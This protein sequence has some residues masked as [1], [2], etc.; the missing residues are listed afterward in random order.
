MSNGI[1]AQRCPLCTGQPAPFAAVRERRYLRCGRCLLTFLDPAQRPGRDEERAEYE[2]HENDPGD[3]GYRRFLSRLTDALVERLSPDAE[4]LDYGCGPG[5]AIS[6]MLGERGIAVRDYDPFF[7]PDSTA[8]DRRYDFVTCTEVVEH[9]HRPGEEFRRFDR[10]LRPGGWLAVMTGLLTDDEG[11]AD[12]WYIREASHV[13]FYRPE[14]MAWIA[15]RFDWTAE[16]PRP[17][18][19]LFRKPQAGTA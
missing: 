15:G 17:N 12:W 6:A 7:Y 18:V 16:Y 1:G 14:T 13:T 8:L 3:P 10:L 5:P 11:F 19:I 4:G 2:L 9:F